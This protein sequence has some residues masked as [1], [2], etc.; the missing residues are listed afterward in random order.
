[1]ARYYEADPALASLLGRWLA[2]RRGIAV[3]EAG[4][5]SATHVSLPADSI[6]TV[7]DISEEQLA[8]N[9]YAQ[10]KIFGDLHEYEFPPSHFD[11]IV[12]WDVFEHLD[13]PGKV[14]TSFLRAVKPGGLIVIAAPNRESLRGTITRLT[15]HR[16]HVFVQRR[17]FGSRTA[18]LPGFPPFPTFMRREMAPSRLIE[19][20]ERHGFSLAHYC[21]YE[22]IVTQ[23]LREEHPW[24]ARAFDLVAAAGRLGTGGR[25]QPELSDFHLVLARPAEPDRPAE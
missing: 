23:L 18:G 7:I 24:I 19:A 4:G 5:G 2:G 9:D 8:R 20:A 21:A 3:L 6:V 13:D 22:S 16:F 10:V 11:L 25:W 12:C 1:M 17:I 14:F 15:P